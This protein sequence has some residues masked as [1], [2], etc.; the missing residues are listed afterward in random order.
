MIV[1][2][3]LVGLMVSCSAPAPEK[4]VSGPQVKAP[5]HEP[6]QD[7][8][9]K[10]ALAG[11]TRM[12]VVPDHLLGKDF[13]PGGNLADYKTADG[14]YQMF[15]LKAADA[16]KAAFLLLDWKSAMAGSKYLAHMGG[17]FGTDQG[18]PIYIFA[19]GPYVAGLVGLSEEKADPEAR[20]FAAKL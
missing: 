5:V 16:Q 8:Q 17:Y 2:A 11:Q 15:L 20:R 10:F 1:V 19:K 3:F 14:E 4:T 18:K 6:P 12:R 7:L 9:T 13:M